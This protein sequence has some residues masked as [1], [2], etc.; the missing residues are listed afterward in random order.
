[1]KIVTNFDSKRGNFRL[2]NFISSTYDAI[3]ILDCQSTI[4]VF[5]IEM[6][7]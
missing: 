7:F 4:P 2:N 5:A 3:P 1:M 6:H